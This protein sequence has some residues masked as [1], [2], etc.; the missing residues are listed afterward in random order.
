M[1]ILPPPYHARDL[2]GSE[3]RKWF[4][5]LSLF[6]GGSGLSGLIP[7]RLVRAVTAVSVGTVAT[8][9][10]FI[11]GTPGEITVTDNGNGT[12]TLSLD[13]S[14]GASASSIIKWPISGKITASVP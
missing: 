4:N 9:T 3:W 11:A 7:G 14:A 2:F 10:A 12:V 8:L 1:A 13:A 6:A 5:S